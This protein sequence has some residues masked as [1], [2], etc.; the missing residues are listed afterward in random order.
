MLWRKNTHCHL[1]TEKKNKKTVNRK[2]KNSQK[3]LE[4]A[5]VLINRQ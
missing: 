1:D 2:P 4:S 5:L 3:K